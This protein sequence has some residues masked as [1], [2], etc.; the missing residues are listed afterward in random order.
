MQRP[1][2]R[3]VLSAVLVAVVASSCIPRELRDP[4]DRKR[5]YEPP[6]LPDVR[7]DDDT[8]KIL[9]VGDAGTCEGHFV[10]AGNTEIR[11]AT[12]AR[13]VRQCEER[14]CDA[15]VLLG[16]NLY[17]FGVPKDAWDD[18]DTCIGRWAYMPTGR[19]DG[20][21]VQLLGILGNHDWGMIRL[22]QSRAAE[23]IRWSHAFNPADP[24]IPGFYWER[25]FD[26]DTTSLRLIAIDSEH[27]VA[28]RSHSRQ[29]KW[30][31]DLTASD[32]TWTF[33]LGH[34]PR[35]SQGEHGDAGAFHDFK[36]F[37]W[38]GT[39]FA[40]RLD[41]ALVE[42]GAHLYAHGHEHMLQYGQV[43]GVMHIGSGGAAKITGSVSRSSAEL[44]VVGGADNPS[45][46]AFWL[47]LN[48]T[49]ATLMAIPNE[50]RIRVEE[51]DLSDITPLTEATEAVDDVLEER[52]GD[53]P[54]LENDGSV[55]TNTPPVTPEER[56]NLPDDAQPI[57]DQDPAESGPV[58]PAEPSPE[59]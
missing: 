27:M 33:I 57:D 45:P 46:G 16:D 39:R 55:P 38:R 22:R 4:F 59:E 10:K 35:Y 15:V 1:R 54:D 53:G 5:F 36:S 19:G 13:S 32:A 50:G 28:H 25:R 11:D 43:D 29:V 20:S 6:D 2:Y 21:T 9:L 18:A 56:A 31:E 51:W 49:H 40:E 48:G 8:L 47:E 14:G 34:H 58:P 24:A 7:I 41:E 37:G 17:T 23:Q 44:H 52:E 26:S 12:F 42:T 30:L 3:H